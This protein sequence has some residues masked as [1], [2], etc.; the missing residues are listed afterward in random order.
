[1]LFGGNK[2]L[3]VINN[4]KNF[5]TNFKCQNIVKIKTLWKYKSHCKEFPC[6][7]GSWGLKIY[8]KN[9]TISILERWGCKTHGFNYSFDDQVQN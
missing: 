4:Y 8:Y 9:G 1:M 6:C 3:T 2:K 5:N 7:G